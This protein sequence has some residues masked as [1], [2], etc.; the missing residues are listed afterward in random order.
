MKLK[1]WWTPGCGEC[2]D[3]GMA[4][5]EKSQAHSRP[6]AV[7]RSYAP[8][9]PHVDGTQVM[10]NQAPDAAHGAEGIHT[11]PARFQSPFGLTSVSLFISFGNVMFN[12]CH[13]RTQLCKLFI[14]NVTS[15][16][17]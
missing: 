9:A 3:H 1:L 16:I 6:I 10:L 8:Q 11:H 2:Q 13:C 15:F 5:E 4:M 12:M 7:V 17:L 14:T